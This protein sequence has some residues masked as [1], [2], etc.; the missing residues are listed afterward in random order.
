MSTHQPYQD[1]SSAHEVFLEAFRR[2]G[3]GV[4]IVTTRKSSGEP[5]GF[6]ATSLAS[7]SSLPPRATFNM[8]QMASSYPAIRSGEYVLIH[9]LSAN[10]L[11]LARKFSGDA[12]E[13]FAGIALQDGPMG[14]P[15]LPGASA[16]V[17]AKIV[18]RHETGDAATI[19]VE[20]TG[21]GLGEPGDS[22]VYQEKNYR[23]AASLP[24]A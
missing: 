24:E 8:S 20:I 13:R 3:A 9:F 7:L 16:Y 19:A 12:S 23:V 21:G 18:A 4:A 14:L 5:T 15:L 11:D 17:V 1:P 22:L 2:H 6:T 10:N